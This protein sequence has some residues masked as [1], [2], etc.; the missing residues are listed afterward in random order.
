MCSVGVLCV[1]KICRW[2]VM[3]AN[4]DV[5]L[6]SI[7]WRA[8]NRQGRAPVGVAW[9]SCSSMQWLQGEGR[10]LLYNGQACCDTLVRD[11]LARRSGL[12][13]VLIIKSKKPKF[14][15]SDT[16]VWTLQTV[17]G[18]DLRIQEDNSLQSTVSNSDLTTCNATIQSTVFLT[19][20]AVTFPLYRY[21]C[22][23]N[24]NLN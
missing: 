1:P 12:L 2:S 15:L 13:V 10:G 24:N 14:T 5:G 23:Q 17:R 19:P 4:H 9:I 16:E 20:H 21:Q 22:F 7:Q 6:S 3:S 11:I 18:M 8:S